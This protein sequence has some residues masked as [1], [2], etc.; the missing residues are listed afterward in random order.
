M[1]LHVELCHARN[2]REQS[3]AA[4]HLLVRNWEPTP[5]SYTHLDLTELV[6]EVDFEKVV[7][8]SFFA[9]IS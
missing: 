7:F 5:L 2:E 1:E 9:L 4:I 8:F 6:K 3:L